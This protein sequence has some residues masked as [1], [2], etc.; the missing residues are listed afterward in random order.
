MP[1]VGADLV[2]AGL[3]A[4]VFCRDRDFSSCTAVHD[5]ASVKTAHNTSCK[6]TSVEAVR[7]VVAFKAAPKAG[8]EA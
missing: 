1:K 3:V 2:D 7:I 5:V 6:V 8:S 4:R